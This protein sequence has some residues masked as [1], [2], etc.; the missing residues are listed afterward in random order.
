MKLPLL[1]LRR[2]HAFSILELLCA[3]TV[4]SI[5]LLSVS[6]MVG[7][8]TSWSYAARR[9]LGLTAQSRFTMDRL[10][11]DFA[12]RVRKPTES[13]KV[14]KA[15]QGNDAM[16]ILSDV[17]NSSVSSRFSAV[18]YSVAAAPSAVLSRNEPQLLR[19]L[20]PVEWNEEPQQ[21]IGHLPSVEPGDIFSGGCLRLEVAFL[22]RNGEIK[23]EAPAR[24]EEIAALLVGMALMDN[25][26]RARYTPQQLEDLARQLGDAQ[27]GKS[28]REIWDAS[29]LSG[30]AARDVR[31]SH[32]TFFFTPGF[33]S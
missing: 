2:P 11:Q 14:F 13:V 23:A 32:K 17:R 8:A 29:A 30:P 7:S 25:A 27:D 5:L 26:A 9:L 1:R 10:D 6:Q 18:T 15:P 31:F 28:P 16:Q 24:S 19:S 12:S 3:I 33:S 22:L 4:L 21:V 20:Q